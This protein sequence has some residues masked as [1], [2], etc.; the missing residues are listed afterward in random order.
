MN[1]FTFDDMINTMMPLPLKG[2]ANGEG[3]YCRGEDFVA[4]LGEKIPESGMQK[5]EMH[6]KLELRGLLSQYCVD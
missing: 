3:I 2:D 4:S 1:N 5:Q 6:K